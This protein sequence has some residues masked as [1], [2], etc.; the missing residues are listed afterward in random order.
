MVEKTENREA[1]AQE[2]SNAQGVIV[3][4]INVKDMT[5]EQLKDAMMKAVNA[6]GQREHEWHQA[7]EAHVNFRIVMAVLIY[8]FDRRMRS[9]AIVRPGGLPVGGKLIA[10]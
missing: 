6:Q 9:V 7:V 5:D 1:Q 3:N 4:G 8:E 2:R 10:P